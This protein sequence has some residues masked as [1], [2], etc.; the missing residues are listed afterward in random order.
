MKMNK[1]SG[2]LFAEKV[3]DNQAKTVGMAEA[4]L[5]YQCA[6]NKAYSDFDDLYLLPQG[7]ELIDWARR[8]KATWWYKLFSRI[9]PRL[10]KP[11][12]NLYRG[13]K[14]EIPNS[15]YLKLGK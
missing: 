6:L 3:R 8:V 15:I 1:E 5:N 11:K 7:K 9:D 13:E 10:N 4:I 2:K 14:Q 12:E